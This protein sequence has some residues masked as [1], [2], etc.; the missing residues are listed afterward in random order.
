[1]DLFP[2]AVLKSTTT[3]PYYNSVKTP[4]NLD[5]LSFVWEG[6]NERERFRKVCK[7]QR[8]SSEFPCYP[9]TENFVFV[10]DLMLIFYKNKLL[11][12]FTEFRI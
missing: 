12:F 3:A 4:L 7:C 5:F 1:M 2:L 10:F 8:K 11:T 9:C 6:L